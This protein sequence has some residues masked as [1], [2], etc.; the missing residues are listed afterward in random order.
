MG[1]P[2]SRTVLHSLSFSKSSHEI[3]DKATA[4]ILFLVAK[5]TEREGRV[6]RLRNEFEISDADLI[7]LLSQAASDA[8]SNARVATTMSYNIGGSG[9]NGDVRVVAAGVVQNLLTEQQL[10]EQER[11]L[12]TKLQMVI[13]NLRP[14]VHY[15]QD[16]GA[17]YEV[18]S[19]PL[20]ESDLDFLGF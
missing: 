13:R 6:A 16:T 5:I 20:S 15:A 12:V 9:G 14:V 19:F 3:K 7:K 10:I 11:D 17:R 8:V 18:D 2:S 1:G 4:K